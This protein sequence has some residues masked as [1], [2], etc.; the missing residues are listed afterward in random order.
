MKSLTVGRTA[1]KSDSYVA[2][3]ANAPRL[4]LEE[5]QA[6]IREVLADRRNGFV[7]LGQGMIGP[8][9]LK[10]RYEGVT[11]NV[12]SEDPLEPGQD[13][14]YDVQ[15]DLG[16]AYWLNAN[17]SEVSATMFEGKRVRFGLFR[18]AAFP[19]VKKE[20][21]FLLKYSTVE[22]AQ[23]MSKQNI[24]KQE[25]SKLI[26]L[27]EAALQS[28]ATNPNHT[29]TPDHT[30]TETSG[31]FTDGSFYTA[32]GLVDPHEIE[33]KVVLINNRDKRDLNR[34]DVNTTG[35]AFKDQVVAGEKITTFGE[36]LFQK[37]I[38]VTPGTCYL[39]PDPEF[40]GVMPVMYSLDVE[41]NPKVEAFER[42]WVMDELIGEVILNPRGIAKIVK[43]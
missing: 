33:S 18:C 22:H 27:L 37:S 9:Q 26:Y 29:A 31:M 11:R 35:W 15:D 42:G 12:L 6:K 36:F 32:A 8:V 23:D 1:R 3:L 19:K 28:Y 10:L 4:S 25:D 7:R 14:V 40:L 2:A 39:L 20:D 34:W 13:L 5:K 43:P 21:E 24:Q 16:V 38:L 30:V 17:E 41:A